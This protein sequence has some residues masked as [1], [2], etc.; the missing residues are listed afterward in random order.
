MPLQ[1]SLTKTQSKG[2]QWMAKPIK[3]K[4]KNKRKVNGT[5]KL[6][7][8]PP[9]ASSPP[10]L[11]RAGEGAPAPE[12]RA[13]AYRKCKDGEGGGP[14]V[15]TPTLHWQDYCSKAHSS[16]ERRC[17]QQDRYRELRAQQQAQAQAQA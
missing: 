2:G 9:S 8:A 3:S 5:G 14:K 17:R 13:C 1:A 10:V 7:P 12:P 11:A 6:K 4:N 15:F 16:A